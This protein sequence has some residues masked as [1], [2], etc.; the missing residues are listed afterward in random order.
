VAARQAQQQ[1]ALYADRDR[2]A[3]D[4]HDQV[5]QRLFAA[6]MSLESLV[7]QVP[8]AAQPRL[9]R[10]VDDL[11]QSIRDIRGTIYALQSPPTAGPGL[12][13]RL[14]RVAEEAVTGSGLR[15]DLS[16]AG[17]VDTTVPPEV[18]EHA[19]AV[20]REAVTNVVRHAGASTVTVAVAVDDRFHLDVTD[21]GV[22]LAPGGRRSGLANLAGRAAEL[23]GRLRTGPG[24]GGTGTCL[25]WEVPLG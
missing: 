13:Q 8:P 17:P 19:A 7:R 15:L 25:T 9:H 22:G 20:L 4:L 24:P 3:R 6:G 21:D 10:A 12:R 14:V 16:S 23:G 11:D 5:I 1:L 2:I 18:A